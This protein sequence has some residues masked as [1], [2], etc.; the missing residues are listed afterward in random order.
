MVSMATDAPAAVASNARG[1][2]GT[3]TSTSQ[4]H[5]AANTETGADTHADAPDEPGALPRGGQG[6]ARP[7]ADVEGSAG[8][9][10][11][12]VQFNLPAIVR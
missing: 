6:M 7:G 8:H 3:A 2:S 11:A 10:H 5:L 4:G 9:D 1:G 12:Q